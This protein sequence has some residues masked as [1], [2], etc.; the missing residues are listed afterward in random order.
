MK[1]LKY[2]EYKKI[3]PDDIPAKDEPSLLD[4]PVSEIIVRVPYVEGSKFEFYSQAYIHFD[5]P[6]VF[7]YNRF[8]DDE[9]IT[10]NAGDYIRID[11]WFEKLTPEEFEKEKEKYGE[12][13]LRSVASKFDAILEEINKIK[14]EDSDTRST[15][16]EKYMVVVELKSKFD[17]S[18][19]YME[20]TLKEKPFEKTTGKIITN[21]FI[22]SKA[23]DDK[24]NELKSVIEDRLE[25]LEK[26][27]NTPLIENNPV[28]NDIENSDDSFDEAE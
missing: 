28:D 1:T 24:F 23:F 20:Q 26:K 9:K 22:I 8:K 19:P 25:D 18:K 3:M 7:E 16:N 27:I 13:S 15:L 4:L 2:S 21:E 6:A 5:E 11:N 14:V 10:I 17:L 12:S